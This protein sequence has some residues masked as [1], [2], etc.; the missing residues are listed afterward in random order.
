MLLFQYRE[1]GKV[2]IELLDTD[3]E[4]RGVSEEEGEGG[5]P[6]FL[7]RFLGMTVS[8]EARNHLAKKPVFLCRS[9][10][11]YRKSTRH[12]VVPRPEKEPVVET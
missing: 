8:E 7:H 6:A 12:K 1:S 9:V 10:R 4:S 2:S 11:R 3:S 5:D